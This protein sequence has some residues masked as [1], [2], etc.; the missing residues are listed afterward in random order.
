MVGK[1]FVPRVSTIRPAAGCNQKVIDSSR[2]AVRLTYD[3]YSP[4]FVDYRVRISRG[5]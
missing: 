2:R 1:I 3:I 4:S 5:G